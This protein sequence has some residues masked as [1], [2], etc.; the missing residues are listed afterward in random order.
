M[1]HFITLTLA[2][3]FVVLFT[4]VGFSQSDFSIEKYPFDDAALTSAFMD[5]TGFN[6][7]THWDRKFIEIKATPSGQPA[8]YVINHTLIQ[9]NNIAA[10]ESNNKVYL[11][12]RYRDEYWTL[13]ARVIK[14]GKVVFTSKPSDIKEVEVEGA[15]YQQLALEKVDPG[16][17]IETIT[18]YTQELNLFGVHYF[19]SNVVCRESNFTMIM[20]D[21]VKCVSKAYNYDVA[22]HDSVMDGRLFHEV[23]LKMV[24]ASQAEEYT[25]PNAYLARLEY[26]ITQNQEGASYEKWSDIGRTFYERH[27]E[28]I[29][30]NKS[31]I[32][33]LLKEIKIGDKADISAKVFAIE[34]YV[35][36]NFSIVSGASTPDNMSDLIKKKYSSPYGIVRLYMYLYH[37]AEVPFDILGTCKKS[38]KFFDKDFDSQSFVKDIVFYFPDIKSYMDP[39][40]IA[41]RIPIFSSDYLGQD[42]IRIRT[43]EIG[44]TTTTVI[45]TVTI[46]ENPASESIIQENYTVRF[47]ADMNNT[48]TD[49]SRS[50]SAFAHQN[51]RGACYFTNE[52]DRKE[53]ME[54][55]IKNFQANAN[56]ENLELQNYDLSSQKEFNLPFVT[57][58]K[59]TGPDLL[60]SAGNKTIF[61]VGEVIGEQ[62]TMYNEKPRQNPINVDFTH[63]Y[64]REI[65]VHIPTGMKVSVLE[66]LKID[67]E[68]KSTAGEVMAAFHSE[69]ELKGD[70]LII[71]IRESY[72]HMNLPLSLYE[73]FRA[74]VNAAA[75]FN[76]AS[77]ILE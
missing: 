77:L 59:L 72:L 71:R 25:V 31:S 14:D 57:K 7:C 8:E 48:I 13:Q 55:I 73:D 51:L 68:C 4:H 56:L 12:V 33:K 58:A 50:Y 67:R 63:E 39:D 70:Q 3:T 47:S 23:K 54:K 15:I 62:H 21:A 64:V 17:Y 69:Y 46:P 29:E 36:R 76:R 28:H 45:T 32:N 60:E 10:A 27:M 44:G 65:I 24:P 43:K 6:T 20:P 26:R 53:L 49:Y 38:V 35:K 74:V 18:A 22:A 16:S 41:L 42:A 11:A 9:V 66:N 5:S 52:D 37:Y 61:K 34:D 30:D 19:Q 40:E 2:S 75:D 1:K